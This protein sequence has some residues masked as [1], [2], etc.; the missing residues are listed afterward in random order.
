M[1]LNNLMT[2][3]VRGQTFQGAFLW[4]DPDQDHLDHGASKGTDESTLDKD[5]SVL[6]MHNDPSELGSLVLIWIIPKEHT[7]RCRWLGSVFWN[8][9]DGYTW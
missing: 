8:A 9:T 6:L 7:P 5:P 3:H 1:R 2:S 4:D